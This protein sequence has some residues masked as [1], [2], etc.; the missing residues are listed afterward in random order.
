MV[1][2]AT[3]K[4]NEDGA[5]VTFPGY[6]WQGDASSG[7]HNVVYFAEGLP[8]YCVNT[9]TELYERLR[10][11][12]AIAIPHHTAYRVGLRGKDWSVH[13]DELS[14]FAEQHLWHLRCD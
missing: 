1:Q 3:R 6:E 13:D 8:V 12:K 4:N 10:Q 14:P 7:D 5:F 2:D 11:H 9:L